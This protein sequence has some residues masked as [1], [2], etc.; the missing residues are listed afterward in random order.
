MDGFDAIPTVQGI[1]SASD[2]V[3]QAVADLNT[4]LAGNAALAGV[5]SFSI[6][7]GSTTGNQVF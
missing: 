5:Y 4:A 7:N 2:Q 1:P 6:N 3:K